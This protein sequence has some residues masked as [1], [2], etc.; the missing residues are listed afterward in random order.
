MK[1]QPSCDKMN[2]NDGVFDDAVRTTDLRR[3]AA[4]PRYGRR[5]SVLQTMQWRG[6]GV[7]ALHG[8][9]LGPK[10]PP[11]TGLPHAHACLWD[12]H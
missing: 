10:S 11:A 2:C 5:E 3:P 9:C 8:V 7:S 6:G 4:F 1:N 12:W